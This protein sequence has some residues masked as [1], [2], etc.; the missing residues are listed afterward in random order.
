[1]SK[2][3]VIGLDGGTFDVVDYLISQGRLPYFSRL[4]AE[5]S[6]G[7]LITTRPPLTPAAWASFY[8]G[9]NPGKHG[10]VDFFCRSRDTYSL[11]PVSAQTVQGSP[12]WSIASEQGKRVCVFNVPLTY[13]ALPV[14]GIMISGMD[15]PGLT[16]QAFFPR[17]F[18]DEIIRK[19]PDFSIEPTHNPVYINN[20]FDDPA[21][22]YIQRLDAYL[23]L[24][25]DVIRHLAQVEDWD[26]FVA[27]IR[28]PDSFQHT[29]WRSVDA[30]ITRGQEN[31]SQE[32]RR[33]A[34][35]VFNCY[36]SIDRELG[37]I[38]SS[39]DEERN[40]VIMSDHGFGNLYREVS[41]NR[42]LSDAGLL[43]FRQRNMRHRYRYRVIGKISS[44]LQFKTKRDISHLLKKYSGVKSIFLN[45]L[46]DDVDW[47]KTRLY[48]LGQFG[49]LF[50]NMVG[51]EPMGTVKNGKERLAMLSEAEAALAEFVD[52]EDGLPV[53]TEFHRREELFHGP[54][55]E[56]L[57]AM[58]V[59]MRNYS[60]RG[61]SSIMAEL[62]SDE[63]IRLPHPEW[64]DLAPTGC[65]RL[66]GLLLMHG[67][68][69]VNID[70][71]ERKITDVTPTILNLM[72]LPYS[73]SFDGEII[74]GALAYDDEARAGK[75]RQTAGSG[76]R[77]ESQSPYSESDEEL[78][79]KKLENLGYL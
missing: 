57:P 22:E 45:M 78:I 20:R 33:R 63:I 67:P 69:I 44:H 48:S 28:S 58:V 7:K 71:G 4:V 9:T 18:K 66:E 65:H 73:D 26:L 79:R 53:L 77:A 24:Q 32:D 5:G 61:V 36:E 31:V 13:P 35:A 27:V 54:K 42:V 2:V 43:K 64:E 1:L 41:L 6:R 62:A 39:H 21:G 49:C 17:S 46:S 56:E 76:E 19:F 14:N 75:G 37:G 15:A 29:F 10:V 55:V 8:T 40:L 51:R 68:D 47:E 38:V 70:L 23:K 59:T 12:V 16:E 34:E 11:S 3:C 52:P 72:D 25:I 50:T 60:Y 30:V 74:T